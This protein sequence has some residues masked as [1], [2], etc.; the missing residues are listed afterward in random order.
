MSP[1]VGARRLR[2][3]PV[4]C[5]GRGLCAELLHELIELD[6]WGF[7]LI[8]PDPVPPELELLALRAASACPVLALR[9]VPA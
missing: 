6:E 4:A 2:L 9:L 1:A 7:P 5:D 8:S 3:D